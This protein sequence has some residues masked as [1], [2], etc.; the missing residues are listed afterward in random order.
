MMEQIETAK[1]G[2]EKP[3]ASEDELKE[4]EVRLKSSKTCT[5]V[6]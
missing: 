1:N 2:L 4:K 3:F 5:S 6:H